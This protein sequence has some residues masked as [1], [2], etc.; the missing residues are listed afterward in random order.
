[1]QTSDKN[2]ATIVR[3][4]ELTPIEGADRIVLAKMDGN[5]WQCVTQKDNFVVGDLA[6]Y[7]VIDSIVD[8]NNPVL[9]F[10]KARGGVVWPCK[11]KKKLSQG[12][13]MPLDTLNYWDFDFDVAEG[14]DVSELTCTTKKI[15]TEDMPNNPEAEGRFPS[16]IISAT[17]E[18]NGHSQHKAFWAELQG[19]KV[20]I[21][22]KM[23]GSS[24]T[25]LMKDLENFRA[26][27]RK[28]MLRPEANNPWNRMA[29]EYDLESVCKRNNVVIQG[30][31][32]G[33]K[34]NGNKMGFSKEML[35]VFDVM[36][37]DR[38]Y[39]NARELGDFCRDNGLKPVPLI[40]CN[41]D[42][43]Y[44]SWDDLIGVASLMKNGNGKPAE[45]IVIRATDGRWSTELDKRLSFKI[46]N[47]NYKP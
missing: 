44:E 47:P 43:A 39:M 11:F 24:G 41:R 28:Q 29:T 8:T 14:D 32:C 6:V 42:F 38:T 19:I 2:L 23:D 16:N 26:C 18:L 13:L 36:R 45:G 20:D 5:S 17:D 12:L 40:D 10:M 3:V 46:I 35:F 15:R 21:T 7:F 4:S 1:M 9:D 31:V 30:E 25:F 27:S 37:D 34:L 22:L 33:P